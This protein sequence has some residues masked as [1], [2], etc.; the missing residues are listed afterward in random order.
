MD[1]MTFLASLALSP[2]RS[3]VTNI[4][5]DQVIVV[6]TDR[7]I[8]AFRYL[9]WIIDFTKRDIIFSFEFN[10]VGDMQYWLN[11]INITIDV[12]D[13]IWQPLEQFVQPL[14]TDNAHIERLKGKIERYVDALMQAKKVQ[15]QSTPETMP[16][17]AAITA[18]RN[19]LTGDS[20][21]YAEKQ[22]PWPPD[23][24]QDPD[25]HIIHIILKGQPWQIYN[26]ATHQ[27]QQWKI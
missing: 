26:L 14:F 18:M 13:K 2:G 22:W 16:L 7:T 24:V 8:A 4:K 20:I 25:R 12:H 1:N 17:Y 19:G 11:R 21:T 15:W 6:Q 23:D 10:I 27:W 5:T 3:I 9:A